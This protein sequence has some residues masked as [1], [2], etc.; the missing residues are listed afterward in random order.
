M[1][2]ADIAA[3]IPHQGGMCLLEDVI[4]WDDT[5]IVLTTTTHRSADNP[6]RVDGKLRAVH[7][8]EY[9]A[10]AMAVHGALKAA[11]GRAPPGMLVSLRSVTFSRDCIHDLAGELRIEAVCLQA[12]D[13]SQQYNFRVSHDGVTL[14]EGRAA[15][16]L[17]Q[18]S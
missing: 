5:R 17:M 7:L 8:C 2:H 14:A 3:L 13:S 1:A 9:G 15:V 6:L 16:L 11:P 12:T 4:E 10:Q 18:P